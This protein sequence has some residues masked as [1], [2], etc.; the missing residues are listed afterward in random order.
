MPS[1]LVLVGAFL[2]ISLLVRLMIAQDIRK[3]K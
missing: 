3:S 2:M 1:Y